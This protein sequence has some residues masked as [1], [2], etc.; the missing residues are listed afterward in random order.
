MILL[1]HLCVLIVNVI[2]G[3]A[4]LFIVFSLCIDSFSSPET[5]GMKEN[6]YIT[7]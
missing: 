2:L 4:A 5:V 3:S 6:I 7:L 1:F